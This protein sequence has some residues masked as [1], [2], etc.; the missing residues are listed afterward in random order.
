MFWRRLPANY[1]KPKPVEITINAPLP[2][3]E[4]VRLHFEG[5]EYRVPLPTEQV[6]D[7]FL[8]RKE[9]SLLK[10]SPDLAE[11]EAFLFL[12]GYSSHRRFDPDSEIICGFYK[13]GDQLVSATLQEESQT[14]LS[15]SC[16]GKLIL[17]EVGEE[18]YRRI[19][20]ITLLEERDLLS[21][22]MIATGAIETENGKVMDLFDLYRTHDP[23]TK[24]IVH[25][26]IDI[27]TYRYNLNLM[28]LRPSSTYLSRERIPS[29][30]E[31]PTRVVEGIVEHTEVKKFALGRIPL[32][33]RKELQLS[34]GRIYPLDQRF[35]GVRVPIVGMYTHPFD[36]D[37]IVAARFDK[38][39]ETFLI[40]EIGKTKESIVGKVNYS[41]EKTRVTVRH[42]YLG[43]ENDD[44]RWRG[45]GLGSRV[46]ETVEEV[47][48]KQYRASRIIFP[49]QISFVKEGVREDPTRF[50]Y[51]NGYTQKIESSAGAGYIATFQ[52]RL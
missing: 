13:R 19:G 24:M 25:K 21:P 40:T 41:H 1:A 51:R 7:P 18:E 31:E 50:F 38:L 32:R 2:L 15:S 5:R 3:E 17:T 12:V 44:Q 48:K 42:Y 14:R 23:F 35:L 45:K 43:G 27:R 20:E 26:M 47:F 52:K 4:T 22:H 36:H 37:K 28:C 11:L 29:P 34:D 6:N 10:Y 16:K 9:R 49:E 30:E 33:W 39:R 8:Q 46:L